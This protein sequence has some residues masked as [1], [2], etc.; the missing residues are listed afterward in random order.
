MEQTQDAGITKYANLFA[1]RK[2]GK[3]EAPNSVKYAAC[4]V[5]NFNNLDGSIT[6]REME[7]MRVICET[8]AGMITNQ[9]A[10]PDPEGLGKAYFRQIA[11]HDDKFIP[12]RGT[13]VAGAWAVAR[14]TVDPDRVENVHIGEL[15]FAK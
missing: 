13:G 9:G 2:I 14:Y 10:Y 5:S 12:A 4:S 11:I 1:P 15:D 7:R 3:F 8:G 6:E